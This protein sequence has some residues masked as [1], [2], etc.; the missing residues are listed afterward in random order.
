MNKY[1]VIFYS[2]EQNWRE[3]IKSEK[4]FYDFKDAIKWFYLMTNNHLGSVKIIHPR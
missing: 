4:H 3:N 2:S 1:K